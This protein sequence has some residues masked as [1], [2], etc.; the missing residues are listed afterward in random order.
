VR[1]PWT[2]SS[3]RSW[4]KTHRLAGWIFV[5]FGVLMVVAGFMPSS[6]RWVFGGLVVFIPALLLVVFGYSYR[7]WKNDPEKQAIGKWGVTTIAVP[8]LPPRGNPG[9]PSSARRTARP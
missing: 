2:L 1:T 9:P 8:P 5:A 6:G 4:A 3:E 7:I